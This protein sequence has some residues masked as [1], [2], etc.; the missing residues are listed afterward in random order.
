MNTENLSIL[1]LGELLRSKKIRSVDLV[2]SALDRI[3]QH[4]PNIHAFV[5]VLDAPA[6][7]AAR[8]ADVHLSSGSSSG[9]LCGI[10]YAVKDIFDVKGVRTA[11]QSKTRLQHVATQDSALVEAYNRDGAVL[12]GK[13]TTHEFAIG[14]PCADSPFPFARNPWD[15][16]RIT[17]G[18]STG[19]GAVIAAGITNLALGSDTGGSVRNPAAHCGAVG[20]KPTFGLLPRNGMFPLS[21][22]LDHCGL[23]T[24]YV[25]D[26]AVALAVACSQLHGI[27]HAFNMTE[28]LRDFE[29]KPCFHGI[30]VGV[31]RNFFGVAPECCPERQKSSDRVAGLLEAHGARIVEV[32]LPEYELFNACGRVIM[33]AEGAAVHL[34]RIRAG[35]GGFGRVALSRL[36]LGMTVTAVDLLRAYQLRLELKR[37]VDEVFANGID[38]LLA[39]V[40]LSAPALFED[41]MGS[42]PASAPART[43]AFNVTGHPSV[44]VPVGLDREAL[45]CSVQLIGRWYDEG[46]LLNIASGVERLSGWLDVLLPLRKGHI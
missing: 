32:A 46:F 25:S 38:I 27:E 28:W 39:P 34:D 12:L 19:A 22:S 5:Q 8:L 42:R 35:V 9:L 43:I 11:C 16:R 37:R 17:G 41:E 10:P 20:L 44:A 15:L 4:E 36:V 2:E 23:L 33:L 3:S 1:D 29:G 30:K 18:S 21:D 24:R 7:A 45:P 6:L 31:V 26:S 13:L 14:G 40:I